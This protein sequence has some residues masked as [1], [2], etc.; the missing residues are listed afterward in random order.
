MDLGTDYVFYANEG[1][2]REGNLDFDYSITIY[3]QE[4]QI[5]KG[6]FISQ[7]SPTNFISDEK[8]AGNFEL[9][10]PIVTGLTYDDLFPHRG[11]VVKYQSESDKT[12]TNPVTGGSVTIK[13]YQIIQLDFTEV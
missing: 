4:T 5:N 9:D 12:G 7:S 11:K 1:G 2:Q 13:P 6:G 3:N 8:I 10:L